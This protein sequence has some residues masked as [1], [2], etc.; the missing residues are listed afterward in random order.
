MTASPLASPA[1]SIAAW[2]RPRRTS[3]ASGQTSSSKGSSPSWPANPCA[4]STT[5]TCRDMAPSKAKAWRWSSPWARGWAPRCT[6]GGARFPNLEFGHHPFEKDKTYEERLGQAALDKAGKATWNRRVAR[7]I[8][9]LRRI[10][11]F[12]KLYIGG[13]NARRI[14]LDLPDDVVIVQNAIAFVGGIKLWE[15]GARK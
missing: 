11:N 10:F 14:K 2:S 7:A 1:S 15:L 4:W 8:D 13:G 5:P 9:L 3:M 6:S 12:D